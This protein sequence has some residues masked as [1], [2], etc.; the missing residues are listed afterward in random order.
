MSVGTAAAQLHSGCRVNKT[1]LELLKL[2]TCQK[3]S[4]VSVPSLHL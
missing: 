1:G 2:L 3:T 4:D